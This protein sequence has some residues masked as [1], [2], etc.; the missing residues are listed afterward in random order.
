MDD[1]KIAIGKGGATF[2]IG[3]ITTLQ[4]A[5]NPIITILHVFYPWIFRLNKKHK[6]TL[7]LS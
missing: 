5:D 7:N 6:L 4:K 1:L 3:K 2:E